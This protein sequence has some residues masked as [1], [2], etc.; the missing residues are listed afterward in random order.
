MKK[1]L[2]TTAALMLFT[3]FGQSYAQDKWGLEFRPGVDYATQDIADADLGIRFWCRV[4][5]R[6]SIYA[7]CCCLCRMELQ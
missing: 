2:L 4:N 7:A 1:L 3:L 6:L 5:N